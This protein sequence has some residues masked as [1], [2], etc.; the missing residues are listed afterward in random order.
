MT[1]STFP[2]SL[3]HLGDPVA[4]L[5]RGRAPADRLPDEEP[6]LERH[7]HD[8]RD[9][10]VRREVDRRGR[11]AQRAADV[12]LV[13]LGRRDDEVGVETRERLHVD[14]PARAGQ[15]DRARGLRHGD[16]GGKAGDPIARADLLEQLGGAGGE[17][18]DA[19]GRLGER[20][21]LRVRALDRDRVDAQ[22][23]GLRLG[24]LAA[25]GRAER[26]H[27]E[28][29][30]ERGAHPRQ[31]GRARAGNRPRPENV[32]AWTEITGTTLPSQRSSSSGRSSSRG[33]STARS[34]VT[35]TCRR[36]GS[37]ATACCAE[38]SRRRS[39]RSASSCGLLVIPEVRAV[40]GGL[41]ASSALIG[42]VLG[43]AARS[44]IANFVSGVLIAFTQPL[45]LGDEIELADAAGTVEEVAL[46]YTTIRAPGGARYFVPNEKL[47]SDTIRNLT[48]AGLGR[49]AR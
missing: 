43:L 17:D 35:C 48:I 24:P 12:L 45:R 14:E 47:A 49:T 6:E 37:R 29:E 26:E 11:A 22:L 18:G 44:T 13:G 46:T 4:D 42:I 32:S 30:N 5:V 36:H 10:A 1:G 2:E 20:D 15:L 19:L 7:P 21:R 34:C 8:V 39:S 9:R 3:A 28:R 16:V 25:P 40:A 41:L 33:S 23:G 27:D 38:A 31:Y